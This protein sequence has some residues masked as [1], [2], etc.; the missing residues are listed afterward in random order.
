MKV[1]RGFEYTEGQSFRYFE[2]LAVEAMQELCS[3]CAEIFS[4]FR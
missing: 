2:Y 1:R 4:T 3:E